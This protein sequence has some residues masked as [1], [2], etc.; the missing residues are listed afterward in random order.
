MAQVILRDF[1]PG[2]AGWIA[3]RH[4]ALYA[5]DE[6]FGVEFEAVVLQALAGFVARRTGQ[7]RGWIAEGPDGMR[8]GSLLC[9]RPEPGVAQLRLFLL[10]PKARGTGLAGRML[11]AAVRHACDADAARLLVRTYDRH[12][13]AGRLYARN[14]FVLI[15]EVPAEAFGHR[16]REQTW[17]LDL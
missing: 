6:G 9:T 14:G 13:A 11:R 17:H 12:R 4:G 15:K 16:M 3:M 1:E 7:E 10:E 2:D 5:R 8:L